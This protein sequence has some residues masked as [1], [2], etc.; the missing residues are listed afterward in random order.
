MERLAGTLFVMIL[1]LAAVGMD[2]L[3]AS[4]KHRGE[5]YSFSDHL[6]E[7]TAFV[8]ALMPAG[9][10]AG[11]MPTA[12]EGWTARKADSR[13]GFTMLGIPEDS[14]L[15]A[16]WTAFE[17]RIYPSIEGH[18]LGRRL[19]TDGVGHLYLEI[20]YVPGAAAASEGARAVAGVFAALRRGSA[21][22]ARSPD[23]AMALYARALPGADRAQLYFGDIGGQVY[24][25]A[26]SNVSEERALSLLSLAD[27]AALAAMVEED[28]A[29]TP[30]AVAGADGFGAAPAPLGGACTMDGAR[31][32]CSIGN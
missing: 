15:L 20:L 16:E 2:Y 27:T 30:A 13:D 14:A 6:S 24:V 32:S 19:Y 8:S 3:A 12:P 21:Q 4:S 25:S 7:R 10:I 18:R 17:D 26:L 5:E 11:A 22:V 1:G 31:K 9:G 28:R 29:A 23:G